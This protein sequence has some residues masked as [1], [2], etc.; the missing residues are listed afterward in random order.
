M[1]IVINNTFNITTTHLKR[2]LCS[3]FLLLI[4][5]QPSYA[6]S[7]VYGYDELGRLT[8]DGKEGII[9]IE[10]NNFNKIT[11]ISRADTCHTPDIEFAYDANGNRISKTIIP[12]DGARRKP[13]P[14]WTTTYYQYDLQ[15]NLIA[16]FTSGYKTLNAET[17][18]NSLAEVRHLLYSTAHTG[19]AQDHTVLYE[20]SFQ[21]SLD[22]DGRFRQKKFTGSLSIVSRDNL[23]TRKGEK[24]LQLTDHLGSVSATVSDRKS[25]SQDGRQ[26]E[27][28]AAKMYDPFG[29]TIQRFTS[30]SD[31]LSFGHSGQ[32]ADN[33]IKGPGNA[34]DFGARMYD[35]RLAR[36][37][38]TDPLQTNYP[39]HS[40]YNYVL[41]SPLAFKD[42]DGNKVVDASGNEVT[43]KPYQDQKGQWKVD[44]QFAQGVSQAVQNRFRNSE[45]A[46]L[47]NEGA[48]YVEGRALLSKL[49]RA[50]HG[51]K[52]TRFNEGYL[53]S[54]FAP[55][56]FAVDDKSQNVTIYFNPALFK[57]LFT[58]N[59]QLFTKLDAQER[60][61]AKNTTSDNYDQLVAE[62]EEIIKKIRIYS[63][64][65]TQYLSIEAY[66]ELVNQ[67]LQEI[68]YLQIFPMLDIMADKKEWHYYLDY[69][70]RA[71][72]VNGRRLDA[73]LALQT[74]HLK[75]DHRFKTYYDAYIKRK[76]STKRK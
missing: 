65:K 10:W 64:P 21:S 51:I 35:P 2:K 76:H 48:Q 41:N 71:G 32:Q 18:T 45:A 26:A 74:F 53:Q 47:L 34:Y 69:T 62:R 67:P 9:R 61:I 46:K 31:Y 72:V 7:G 14:E 44:F 6:Q 27:L 63:Y 19:L 36:W 40:P 42:P 75:I 13:E 66:R 1:N 57:K 23:F 30:T 28:L 29:M 60:K 59:R 5:V 68:M 4:V 22:V 15:D 73:Q 16:T 38:S 3:A 55:L 49:N 8:A 56:E 17:F 54:G 39:S 43:L 52:I 70:I 33:E 20:S 37:L 24:N 58:I 50:E 12:R 25:H 11:R